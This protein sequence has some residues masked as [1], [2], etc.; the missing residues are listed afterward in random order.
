ME[1]YRRS[2]SLAMAVR[3][4]SSRSRGM[5]GRI[6]RGGF[7]SRVST[8]NSTGAAASSGKGLQPVSTWYRVA[9]R[10]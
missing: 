1:A 6:D 8:E 2:R 3:Q 7:G 9:P 5:S 10:L 4:M